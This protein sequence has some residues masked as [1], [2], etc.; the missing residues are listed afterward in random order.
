MLLAVIF[1]SLVKMCLEAD[2]LF[3]VRHAEDSV[4]LQFEQRFARNH[5]EVQ[6]CCMA[7]W[8][9]IVAD[10]DYQADRIVKIP[11]Q[12]RLSYPASMLFES[13]SCLVPDP[14]PGALTGLFMEMAS[15]INCL[16]ILNIH[17]YIHLVY[18]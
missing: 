15:G 1:L 17:L 7:A 3:R 4:L 9:T 8:Q 16:H 18:V 14:I 5:W 2:G 6:Q 13:W 12:H 11:L 10:V